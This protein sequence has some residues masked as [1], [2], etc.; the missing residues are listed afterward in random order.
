M[1]LSAGSAKAAIGRETQPPRRW[2]T[3]RS[4]RCAFSYHIEPSGHT[5]VRGPGAETGPPRL[6]FGHPAL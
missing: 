2:R 6:E 5:H 1:A 4:P 3:C